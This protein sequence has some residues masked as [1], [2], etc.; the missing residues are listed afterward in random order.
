LHPRRKKGIERLE[1][2]EARIILKK[3]KNKFGG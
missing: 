1:V 2:V 3:S